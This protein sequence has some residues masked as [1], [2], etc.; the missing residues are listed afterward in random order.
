[1][2]LY[3]ELFYAIIPTLIPCSF[4][5]CYPYISSISGFCTA[6]SRTNCSSSWISIPNSL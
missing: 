2:R 5:I 1:V 4:M 3:T 6:W